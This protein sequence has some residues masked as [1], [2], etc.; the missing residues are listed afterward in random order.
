MSQSVPRTEATGEKELQSSKLQ[1]GTDISRKQK[2]IEL[3]TKYILN[4]LKSVPLFYE[5]DTASILGF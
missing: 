4:F 2:L 1:N 3:I 5:N